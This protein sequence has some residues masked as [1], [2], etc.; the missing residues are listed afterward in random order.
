[1]FKF[2]VSGRLV[3]FPFNDRNRIASA[4][5]VEGGGFYAPRCTWDVYRFRNAA[6]AEWL[7]ASVGHRDSGYSFGSVLHIAK[8]EID[9][10]SVNGEDD[11][12]AL[13]DSD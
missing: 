3:V 1:H 5:S 7:T 9:L 11:N 2:T 4:N 8:G 13:Y 10:Q 12:D 6:T